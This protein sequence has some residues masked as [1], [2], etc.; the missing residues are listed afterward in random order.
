MTP[1]EEVYIDLFYDEN[2]DMLI[3]YTF[4]CIDAKSEE[5]L[6]EITIKSEYDKVQLGGVLDIKERFPDDKIKA[7]MDEFR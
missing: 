2:K 6:F 7:F 5:E 4:S 3:P 1:K